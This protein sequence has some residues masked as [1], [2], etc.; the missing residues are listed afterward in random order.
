STP[1]ETRIGTAPGLIVEHGGGVV[2]AIP[3]VPAE[4][5]EMMSRAVLPDLARR[6]G[7][8]AVT[9]TRVVRVSGMAESSI[10]EALSPLWRSLDD[11]PVKMSYLAGGGEVRVRITAKA[12]DAAAADA[13]L[14]PVERSIR[15]TLG[16]AVVGTGDATLESVVG[17]L[18]KEVRATLAVA[19]SVTGGG[20][21]ERITRIPGSS[22]YF[23]GGVVAY[24]PAVKTALLGVD[25][26]L[27]EMDGVVSERVALAMARGVRERTGATVGL[28]LTG[29]AGPDAHGGMPPGSVWI[30]VDDASASAARLVRY[31]SDR[32][33]VR[34]FATTAA[35][36]LLRLHLS[37]ARR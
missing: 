15:E 19:E 17:D 37:E 14:D 27:I 32:A 31:A 5:R 26:A 35:L 20:V 22:A 13:L 11:A 29:A 30:A 8:T 34:G 12:L 3:G 4:M 16:T 1:I 6:A 33:A 21:A 28:A 24:D 18:L 7:T 23:A 9:R 25:P 36:N 10:A 2:Y